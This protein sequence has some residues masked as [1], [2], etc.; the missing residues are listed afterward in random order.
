[1]V[2]LKYKLLK[3]RVVKAS[4][5]SAAGGV[6]PIPGFSILVDITLLVE[7]ILTYFEGFG[8]SKSSIESLEDLNNVRKGTIEKA[9]K[10][11]LKEEKNGLLHIIREGAPK[12]LSNWIS[13]R[14]A[15]VSIAG[16]SSRMILS[17]LALLA[18]SSAIE[19]TFQW[20][21]PV[22]GSA[23]SAGLSFA[24]TFYQLS[25][26]LTQMK[27]IAM[28]ANSF[29]SKSL[30]QRSTSFLQ[31]SEDNDSTEDIIASIKDE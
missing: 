6:I 4:L 18:T 3:K 30:S 12:S 16:S 22:I 5:A 15:A 25:Y 10:R 29:L 27:D 8:L 31:T 1:M 2:E 11:K 19:T 13:I 7:E 24:V 20:V 26:F 23:A 14:R 28:F 9:L 21:L 17:K